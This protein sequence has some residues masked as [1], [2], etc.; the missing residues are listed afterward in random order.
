MK[1]SLE[2][3]IVLFKLFGLHNTHACIITLIKKDTALFYLHK[4]I[5]D[6]SI[7]FVQ[8]T[9]FYRLTHSYAECSSSP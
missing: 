3:I 4:T 5:L 6:S 1:Q 9:D 7:A 2:K 8:R